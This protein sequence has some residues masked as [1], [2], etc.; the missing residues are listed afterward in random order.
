MNHRNRGAQ[1]S[2]PNFKL[3]PTARAIR[4]ALA[5]S[6]VMLALAGSNAALAGTCTVTGLNEVTC[7]GVFTDDVANTVPV[8]ASVPDLTLI[9]G[10]DGSTTVNPPAG[11]NGIS[12]TWGGDATVISYA[13]INTDGGDG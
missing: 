5:T 12:S 6:T 1:A 3:A 10:D 4:S 9:V 8:I 13:E 7:N 11:S 2:R